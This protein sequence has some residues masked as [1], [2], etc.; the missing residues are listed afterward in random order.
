MIFPVISSNGRSTDKS[1]PSVRTLLSSRHS[2]LTTSSLTVLVLLITTS[3]ELQCKVSATLPDYYHIRHRNNTRVE[4][5]QRGTSGRYDT[6]YLNLF[7][8]QSHDSY[9]ESSKHSVKCSKSKKSKG[10]PWTVTQSEID[11]FFPDYPL[12]V[13]C[14]GEIAETLVNS[15]ES[16][17]ESINEASG[18]LTLAEVMSLVFQRDCN[19]LDLRSVLV[20]MV[21]YEIARSIIAVCYNPHTHSSGGSG[22]SRKL[23]MIFPRFSLAPSDLT[24]EGDTAWARDYVRSIASKSVTRIVPP[25]DALSQCHARC[26]YLATQD[27]PLSLY[28]HPEFWASLTTPVGLPQLLTA[29][30]EE[31]D[32][33]CDY[34]KELAWY[35]TISAPSATTQ[36]A[37]TSGTLQ[38]GVTLPT[39]L[40]TVTTSSEP[41]ATSGSEVIYFSD[42]ANCI[43][44]YQ[45][46]GVQLASAFGSIGP[47]PANGELPNGA[48]F[49]PL[50]T[51]PIPEL[52]KWFYLQGLYYHNQSSFTLDPSPR[53]CPLPVANGIGRGMVIFVRGTEGNIRQCGIPEMDGYGV[54]L[55]TQGTS[56]WNWVSM[57][58]VVTPLLY[59]LVPPEVVRVSS[60]CPPGPTSDFGLDALGRRVV[61]RCCIYTNPATLSYGCNIFLADSGG[62]PDL[63]EV[64]SYR[65]CPTINFTATCCSEYGGGPC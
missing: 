43:P 12:E 63:I 23:P 60:S 47:F 59:T 38:T 62:S 18:G 52:D 41:T 20:S 64:V 53:S 7:D 9:T 2:N 4:L 34:C 30:E 37:T 40:G 10:D 15:I 29:V 11:K 49:F 61:I 31:F 24:Y 65:R 50:L 3:N 35:L 25:R 6:R 14:S 45:A 32:I 27:N 57:P 8:R 44:W 58:G 17:A 55:G 48:T 46:N 28:N 13:L 42:L 26:I 1:S 5:A 54:S 36:S 56:Y 33:D 39:G 19:Y 21:R 22:P 51:C 16:S